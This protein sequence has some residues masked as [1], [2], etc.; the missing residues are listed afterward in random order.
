MPDITYD[1]DQPIDVDVELDSPHVV[2][3]WIW[4]KV[5]SG[6]W[7]LLASGNDQDP[8]LPTGHHHTLDPLPV[9]SRLRVR[10]IF[11]GNPNTTYEGSIELSQGS[12]SIYRMEMSGRTNGQGVAVEQEDVTLG[13][14]A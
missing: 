5:G 2:S 7:R 12:V 9:G 10:V 6:R 14:D 4:G 13:E 11:S 3:W 1:P 8:V